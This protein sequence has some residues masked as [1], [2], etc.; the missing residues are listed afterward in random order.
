LRLFFRSAVLVALFGGLFSGLTGCKVN[1]R[2]KEKPLVTMGKIEGDLELEGHYLKDEETSAGLDRNSQTLAFRE[3]LTL[4]TTGDVYHPDLLAYQV[5]GGLGLVQQFFQTDTDSDNTRE[6][7]DEYSLS[8]QLLRTKPYNLSL[9]ANKTDDITPRQYLGSLRSEN[10]NRGGILSLQVPAWPMRVQWSQ[11]RLSQSPLSLLEEDRALARRRDVFQ[12]DTDSIDYSLEHSFSDTSELQYEFDWEDITRRRVTSEVTTETFRHLLA[13]EWLFGSED[14]HRLHSQLDYQDFQ[15]DF[16]M[17]NLRWEETL[18]LQHTPTFSTQHEIR[19]TDE[20]REGFD[21][22]EIR[23]QTGFRHRL[24]QSLTTRGSVFAA[25]NE[26]SNTA[27]ID[28]WGGAMSLDYRKT[29]PWGV[30]TGVYS[31]NYVNRDTTGRSAV[32]V[33]LDEEHIYHDPFPVILEQTNVDL[34]TIIVTDSENVDIY[35]KGDDYTVSVV[36][37]RVHLNIIPFGGELPNIADG[38][39]LRVDYNFTSDPKSERE[40]LYQD[41]RIQQQFE[42]GISLYY[43]HNRR[44]EDLNTNLETRQPDNSQTNTFGAQYFKT[45]LRLQAEHSDTDSS[46]SSVTS[47]MLSGSYSWRL[48]PRTTIMTD[49]SQH[50]LDYS[51]VN[52]REIELFQAGA[53][54]ISRLSRQLTLTGRAS[55]RNE[56]DSIAGA[57][58]G[59]HLRS[60]MRF[61]YRQLRLTTG[62][63]YNRFDRSTTDREGMHVFFRLKRFF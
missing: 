48:T 57:T 21:Q 49:V 39:T 63:E 23:G 44:D 24:Y 35:T 20:V 5:A 41:F 14:Q 2:G 31:S 9:Y 46:I 29:N 12:Q 10:E 56:D 26:V 61:T 4:G 8:A 13:H 38:Q 52:P 62:V 47:S 3:L 60:E 40:I 7:L 58:R 36:N 32:G 27:E 1:I 53:N 50:W 51:Q 11:S 59:I 43:G 15:G 25:R 42:N 18:D 28:L 37:G 33:V 19:Y 54:L 16:N 34:S 22:E 30:L 6:S 17:E 55:W 45:N